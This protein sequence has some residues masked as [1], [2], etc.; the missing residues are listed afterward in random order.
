MVK[1]LKKRVDLIF[2]L[3]LS[4]SSFDGREDLCP[5]PTHLVASF[6]KAHTQH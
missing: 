1:E 4:I 2:N 5:L 6:L 3:L